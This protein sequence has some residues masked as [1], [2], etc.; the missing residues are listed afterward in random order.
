M[1]LK[2]VK[3]QQITTPQGDFDTRISQVHGALDYALAAGEELG[4]HGIIPSGSFDR[5]MKMLMDAIDMICAIEA[6]HHPTARTIFPN[7]AM[8]ERYIADHPLGRTDL[9]YE[10]RPQD[11]AGRCTIAVLRISAY[12]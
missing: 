6:G 7:R 12:V 1:A 11:G 5:L 8:A 2:L 9:Q 3:S 4:D 10:I